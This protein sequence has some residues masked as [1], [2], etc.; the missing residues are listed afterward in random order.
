MTTNAWPFS[1][2]LLRLADAGSLP[3]STGNRDLAR[4]SPLLVDFSHGDVAAF[5][6]HPR[7]IAAAVDA[8]SDPHSA[9]SPYRGHGNVREKVATSLASFTGRQI[10][11]ATELIITPGTQGGLYLA[12]SSLVGPG[13]LVAIANPDYFAY[14]RIVTYLGA[15]PR[16]VALRS[17]AGVARLDM[18]QLELALTEGARVI[19]LS[20]PN[21]P[22]G[23]IYDSAQFR[24]IAELCE[25]W[26]AFLI[27][28]ELYSRLDYGGIPIAHAWS[29]A[30][31][32]HRSIS[33]VGP[34]KSESLS[35]FRVGVAIAPAKVIDAMERIQ[36]IVSL[37][38]PGYAQAVLGAWFGEEPG[39]MAS[40]IEDH[41]EIRDAIVSR[42]CEIPGLDV[43]LPR[44]GSY[45]FPRLPA[46]TVSTAELL[47]TLRNDAGIVVTHGAEF[48][49][50][51]EHCFRVNFS[52]QAD[53]ALEAADLIANFIADVA[54]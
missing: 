15:R 46:M 35:G 11:P 22:T 34:S 29:S 54:Q 32:E 25:R 28:D 41:R 12:L 6:P 38:A 24:E 9:Y 18:S 4:Q 31:L 48:G 14:G 33:L 23:A 53:V 37:R 39:W 16:H 13:D 50:G 40:R 17:E 51:G 45:L 47:A 2:Q 26:N 42:W 44:A 52:Q 30:G 20:N 7:A 43:S 19:C 3:T 27:S 49:P 5:P 36:S 10:D 21:N 8:V 1:K